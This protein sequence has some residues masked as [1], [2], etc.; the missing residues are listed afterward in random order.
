MKWNLHLWLVYTLPT[1]SME[2]FL[3]RSF[4]FPAIFSRFKNLSRGVFLSQ[5]QE[6][7]GCLLHTENN[8]NLQYSSNLLRLMKHSNIRH[9]PL[10]NVCVLARPSALAILLPWAGCLLH[11]ASFSFFFDKFLWPNCDQFVKNFL[12]DHYTWPY[13]VLCQEFFW[14]HFDHHKSWKTVS[15]PQHTLWNRD[16][17]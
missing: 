13:T 14:A 15:I 8:K 7:A 3:F 1:L 10:G 4:V 2:C 12:C 5:E 9:A 16:A 6:T 17:V 11:G